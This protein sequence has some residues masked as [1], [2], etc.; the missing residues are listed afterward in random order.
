MTEPTLIQRRPSVWRTISAV[1]W[2][3][4]GVRRG[5]DFQDDIKHLNPFHI[6][7]VG[8]VACFVFVGALMFFVRWVVTVA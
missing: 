8:L 7:I 6:L 3:F 1:L 5:A 2:S 4:F